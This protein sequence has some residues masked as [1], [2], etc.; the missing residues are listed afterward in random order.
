MVS[1]AYRVGTIRL[2]CLAVSIILTSAITFLPPVFM[3]SMY[4]ASS[5][6]MTD[7]FGLFMFGILLGGAGGWWCICTC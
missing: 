4:W 7:S 3:V 6:G 1:L 5:I 2:A